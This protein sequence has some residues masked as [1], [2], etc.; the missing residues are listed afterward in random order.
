MATIIE[1]QTR[2]ASETA[3]AGWT[4]R[5]LPSVVRWMHRPPGAPATYRL[6]QALTGH[7]AFN[8]YLYRFGIID[9]PAC[10]HC[11]APADNV[12]HTLFRCPFWSDL[13]AEITA[14]LARPVE[15]DDVEEIMCGGSGPCPSVHPARRSFLDMVERV[16]ATKEDAERE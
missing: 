4:R 11:D 14:V 15:P 7:E 12:E 9:S 8:Q 5:I 6:S 10:P 16:M 2:W 13:R 3:V 1:W